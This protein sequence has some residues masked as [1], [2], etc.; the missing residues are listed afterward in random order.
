MALNHFLF[1][2]FSAPM[3]CT[4]VANVLAHRLVLHHGTDAHRNGFQHSCRP[5]MSKTPCH[6]FICDQGGWGGLAQGCGELRGAEWVSKINQSGVV[7]Y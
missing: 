7:G 2:V 3:P 6:H 1:I 5:S 4:A